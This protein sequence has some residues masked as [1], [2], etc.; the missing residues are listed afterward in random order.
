MLGASNTRDAG[1]SVGFN[2]SRVMRGW[3]FFNAYPG[4][5]RVGWGDAFSGMPAGLHR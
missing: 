3:R 5:L 1:H 4:V 2:A